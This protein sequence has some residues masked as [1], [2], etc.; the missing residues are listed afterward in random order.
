MAASVADLRAAI[1][2]RLQVGA[3]SFDLFT[4][5]G[6]EPLAGSD[7]V[8]SVVGPPP[9]TAPIFMLQRLSLALTHVSDFDT[10]GYF[11]W[12]G[13]QGDGSHGRTHRRAEQ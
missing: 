4:S 8:L 13:T 11:H 10:N 6:E 12:K 9:S 3:L 2:G 1:A 7:Q 5:G